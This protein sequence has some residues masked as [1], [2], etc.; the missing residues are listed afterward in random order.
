MDKNSI[1]LPTKFRKIGIL[2]I[3]SSVALAFVFKPVQSSLEIPKEISTLVYHVLFGLINVGLFAVFYARTH[4]DDEMTVQMKLKAT[5]TSVLFTTL[6]FII[7][8]II[9]TL[10]GNP[11]DVSA[12][13]TIMLIQI[14]QITNYWMMKRKLKKELA[15]DEE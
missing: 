2:L 8:P 14:M 5:M 11:I 9:D 12:A 10:F 6:M 4:K 7:K 15:Y 3:V 13:Y 1:Q